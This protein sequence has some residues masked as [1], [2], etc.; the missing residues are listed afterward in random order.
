M[1]ARLTKILKFFSIPL[2]LALFCG[3]GLLARGSDFPRDNPG[4][5]RGTFSYQMPSGI[6]LSL[7]S[8]VAGGTGNHTLSFNI[9]QGDLQTYQAVITYPGA[10]TYN[11]FLALGS[12]GTQIGSYSFT[13]SS[14][15]HTSFPVYSIDDHQ[16]YGDVNINGSYNSSVDPFLVHSETGGNNVFTITVPDG[17]DGDLSTDL[18][19]ANAAVTSLML[20]GI[21]TNPA[22]P[23]TYTVS[24]EFTSVDPDTGGP[25]NGSGNS[26][27]TLSASKNVTITSA[28]SVPALMGWA[29]V[30]A[31][32]GVGCLMIL[33]PRGARKFGNLGI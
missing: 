12:A 1:G 13:L 28:F 20:S 31:I 16:A 21:L 25:N 27:L 32:F 15:S 29:Y 18:G 2:V 3:C 14:K 10:F 24:G 6:T 11:G 9:L 30:V 8:T 17:G 19:Q 5:D 26:P 7:D 4:N 22:F 33:F 23:G